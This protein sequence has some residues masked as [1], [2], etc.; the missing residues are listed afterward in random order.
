L[1]EERISSERMMLGVDMKKL[2]SAAVL[3]ML[4]VTVSF[5]VFAAGG[6]GLG[7]LSKSPFAYFT[8]EDTAL[9][10]KTL[11]DVLDNQPDGKTVTWSNQ[12]TGHSG[13]IKSTKSYT[14]DKSP[15]RT[16]KF[17]NSANGVTGQGVFE[18]C[19]QKDGSWKIP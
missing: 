12:K 9:F 7:F 5:P 11:F 14:V 8:S 15:C 13:K 10:K 17:F 19:K 6:G 1:K 18:F 16:I 4:T 3:V 2:I